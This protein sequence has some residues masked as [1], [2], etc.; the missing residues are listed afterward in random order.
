MQR[1][2]FSR[3]LRDFFFN[4]I[5]DCIIGSLLLNICSVSFCSD[6]KRKEYRKSPWIVKSRNYKG[7]QLQ[8]IQSLLHYLQS[9][10]QSLELTVFRLG[11]LEGEEIRTCLSLRGFFGFIWSSYQRMQLSGADFW[12][13][14]LDRILL[15]WWEETLLILLHCC[16]W[17]I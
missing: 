10:Y 13:R 8:C 3:S 9:L 7:V 12:N 6:L 4:E 1:F 11:F 14:Y 15:H 17:N 16:K 5:M 2:I